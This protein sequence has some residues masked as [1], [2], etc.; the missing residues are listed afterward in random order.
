MAAGTAGT[1]NKHTAGGAR[2]TSRDHDRLI[3]FHHHRHQAYR[4][5]SVQNC[6]RAAIAL[7]QS[8]YR[9]DST[10]ADTYLSVAID[11]NIA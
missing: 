3:H 5:H 10:L 8:R 7:L 9:M 11:F 6:G 2:R 1:A 4:H